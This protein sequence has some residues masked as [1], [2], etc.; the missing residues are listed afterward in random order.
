MFFHLLNAACLNFCDCTLFGS[1]D[2]ISHWWQLHLRWHSD[3]ELIVCTCSTEYKT[4]H[5]HF[6]TVASNALI[7]KVIMGLPVTIVKQEFLC[8][9]SCDVEKR[10]MQTVR[11]TVKIGLK[12]KCE[13]VAGWCWNLRTPACSTKVFRT[14]CKGPYTYSVFMY[15]SSLEVEFVLWKHVCFVWQDADVPQQSPQ[16]SP[17]RSWTQCFLA[18]IG[19]NLAFGENTRHGREKKRGSSADYFYYYN[20]YYHTIP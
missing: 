14:I 20:Y 5:A 1:K 2:E 3:I 4:F 7:S 19:W 10:E 8:L 6:H 18:G 9:K 11:L 12:F 13:V 17:G 16:Q 15:Y